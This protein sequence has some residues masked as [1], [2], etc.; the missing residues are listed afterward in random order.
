MTPTYF[1]DSPYVPIGGD[2]TLE[3]NLII[4]NPYVIRQG[5]DAPGS[6]AYNVLGYG[7][8]FL[9]FND[10]TNVTFQIESDGTNLVL[11][12]S[13]AAPLWLKSGDVPVVKITSTLVEFDAAIDINITDLTV[14]GVLTSSGTFNASGTS[15]FSGNIASVATF[16]TNASGVDSAASNFSFNGPRST[17]LGTPAGLV[18]NVT[19]RGVTGSTLQTYAEGF[20]VQEI[21]IATGREVVAWNINGPLVA[22][23]PTDVS[24]TLIRAGVGAHIGIGHTVVRAGGFPLFRFLR[25][26]GTLQAPTRAL[27]NDIVAFV[28]A[29]SIDETG[30]FGG[31]G[32]FLNR[33]REDFASTTRGDQWEVANYPIGVLSTVNTA[34]FR[35]GGST[36]SEWLG[37]ATTRIISGSTQFAIRD[38]SNVSDTFTINAAGTTVTFPLATSVSWPSLTSKTMGVQASGTNIASGDITVTGPISTGNAIPGAIIWRVGVQ[39]VSG[40]AAQ[41]ATEAFRIQEVANGSSRELVAWN[42]SGPVMGGFG[43]TMAAALRENNDGGRFANRV[44]ILRVGANASFLAARV[45]TSFATPSALLSS[46]T[47]GLFGFGGYDGTDVFAGVQIIGQASENWTGTNRGMFV[48]FTATRSGSNTPVTIL[49]LREDALNIGAW[50]AAR[51]TTRIISGATNIA[52]RDSSN[53]SDT[54]TVNAA[55]TAITFPLSTSFI[56]GTDPGVGSEN[57]KIGGTLRVQSTG[58]ASVI[59]HDAA[60]ALTTALIIED[61]TNGN[62]L[63][64]NGFNRVSQLFQTT[65]HT[66][67]ERVWG[68]RTESLSGTRRFNLSTY[69]DAGA[70]AG[71][72]LTIFRAGTTP[73]QMSVNDMRITAIGSLEMNATTGRFGTDASGTNVAAGDF[74]FRS[75]RSTGTA[76]PSQ[77]IWQLTNPTGS[78]TTLQSWFTGMTLSRVGS[79]IS[80][81]TISGQIVMT[82]VKGVDAS[83]TNVAASNFT[84]DAGLS[85]GNATPAAI[86]VRVGVQGAS[87]AVVQTATEALRIQEIAN[88]GSRELTV[89]NQPGSIMAGLPSNTSTSFF[90]SGDAI[91]AQ[92]RVRVI[93]FG[94]TPA[95][96]GE[97][98]GG[99]IDA[100]TQTPTGVSLVSLTANARTDTATQVT[101]ANI[102][103]QTR[104]NVTAAAFG[105]SVGIDITDIGSSTIKT[106]LSI[107]GGG[108]NIAELVAGQNTLR[109]IPSSDAIRF[110]DSSNVNDTF[111]VNAAG[112][113]VA[114]PLA[115]DFN[116]NGGAH[117]FT[118]Q[119]ASFGQITSGNVAINIGSG[120]ASFT[121]SLNIRS[122][123]GQFAILAWRTGT[124]LRWQLTKDTDAESGSNAGSTFRMQAFDDTGTFIDNWLSV[125]RPATGTIAIGA[126]GSRSVAIGIDP[127]GTGLLRI[128]GGINISTGSVYRVNNTQVVSAR[129]TGWGAPTG[130]ATRTTFATGSVT[131]AQLAERVKALIDDLTT[132]GLIGA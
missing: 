106:A 126:T 121:A 27:N 58:G 47:A 128:G 33:L 101:P 116:I 14:S 51:P 66:A 64:L 77:F 41:T 56:I 81:L 23:L 28:G 87:G 57:V 92:T 17:G 95:F 60:G 54:F 4:P 79:S 129:V 73:N 19:Q 63:I 131:L 34:I 26:N 96:V 113:S 20:R 94:G 13:T 90:N 31:G 18:V 82:G 30:A 85:T 107:R 71:D 111:T 52:F 130:V 70:V 9:E 97:R 24:P 5:T 83:G 76:N 102:Y 108:T 123:A 1:S 89:W 104:E 40:S 74:A 46:E 15:N 127:G 120:T 44:K 99:T 10:G 118:P 109:I 53:V 124:A 86:V 115:T 112:T 59:R 117:T 11:G 32:T 100:P 65:N 16:G 38:S 12:T 68:F 93:R 105:S 78:G 55:G 114:F 119:V 125:S 67:T 72:A 36:I 39:G 84:F 48:S 110:R 132:H 50:I 69:T 62:N 2:V 91:R 98:T 80:Q 37:L 25:V 49:Q 43:S 61:Y 35:A 42:V 75:S 7:G 3:G 21:A 22:R 45:N 122:A 6:H 103:V 8:N 29:S 88:S